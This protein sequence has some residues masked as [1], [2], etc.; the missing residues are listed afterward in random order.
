MQTLIGTRFRAE[1]ATSMPTKAFVA[2]S[3]RIADPASVSKNG[4]HPALTR[5]PAVHHGIKPIR[6]R[7]SK[8]NLTRFTYETTALQ[9]WRLCIARGGK[10]FVRHFCDEQRGGPCKALDP[11]G[12]ARSCSF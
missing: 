11:I 6:F 10:T 9:G 8:K 4:I 3:S 12:G 7:K 5:A 1:T 2:I